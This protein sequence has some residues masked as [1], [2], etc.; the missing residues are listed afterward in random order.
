MFLKYTVSLYSLFIK[1]I[2]PPIADDTQFKYAFLGEPNE[3]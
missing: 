2:I 1:R 3:D